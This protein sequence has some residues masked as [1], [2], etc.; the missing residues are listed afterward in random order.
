MKEYNLPYAEG[1]VVLRLDGT[2]VCKE[3]SSNLERNG[4]DCYSQRLEGD[5]AHLMIFLAILILKEP[6]IS[7]DGDSV[8]QQIREKLKHICVCWQ[9]ALQMRSCV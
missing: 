1:F 6:V 4:Q 3:D 2:Q 7:G 8:P 9:Q 5:H